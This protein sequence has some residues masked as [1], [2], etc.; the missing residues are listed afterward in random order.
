MFVHTSSCAVLRSLRAP[1]ET[2]SEN[3]QPIAREP[4]SNRQGEGEG[5]EEERQGGEPR[6]TVTRRGGREGGRWRGRREEPCVP[7][8]SLSTRSWPPLPPK[9][10]AAHCKGLSPGHASA[11][12]PGQSPASYTQYR[13]L[14]PPTYPVSR[15][16]KAMTQVAL[17]KSQSLKSGNSLELRKFPSCYPV[18]FASF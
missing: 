3:E 2:G 15:P 8:G 4:D 6:R 5:Q 17:A 7:N 10:P 13:E 1:K 12:K 16:C 18:L 11:A 9:Q 14:C